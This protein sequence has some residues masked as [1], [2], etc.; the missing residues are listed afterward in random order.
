MKRLI[1]LSLF[2]F[3]GCE[4]KQDYLI[5]IFNDQSTK[6]NYYV[7]EFMKT[8]NNDTMRIYIDSMHMANYAAEIALNEMYK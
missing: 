7:D 6:V 5:K 8:N 4:T 2:L 3:I 1:Y